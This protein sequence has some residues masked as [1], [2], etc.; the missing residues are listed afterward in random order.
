MSK[1]VNENIRTSSEVDAIIKVLGMAVEVRNS[2]SIKRIMERDYDEISD[3]TSV[4]I[5][6]MMNKTKLIKKNKNGNYYLSPAGRRRLESIAPNIAEHSYVHSNKWKIRAEYE[7]VQNNI[8]EL[9]L[10]CG[11]DINYLTKEKNLLAEMGIGY[12]DDEEINV[13][14]DSPREILS[15]TEYGEKRYITSRIIQKALVSRR[16][17]RSIADESFQASL[18]KGIL[19]SDRNI[20]YVYKEQPN[21][22]WIKT[23]EEKILLKLEREIKEIQSEKVYEQRESRGNLANAIVVVDNPVDAARLYRN[24]KYDNVY[25]EVYILDLSYVSP[26]KIMLILESAKFNNKDIGLW[27]NKNIKQEEGTVCVELITQRIKNVT[28]IKDFINIKR[29]IKINV[30]CLKTQGV[31]I[32]K[33]FTPKEL[34]RINIREL[35]EEEEKEFLLYIA[36]DSDYA[37]SL[38]ERLSSYEDKKKRQQVKGI[39]LYEKRIENETINEEQKHKRMERKVKRRIEKIEKELGIKIKATWEYES[40]ETVVNQDKK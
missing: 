16:S 11:Y 18:L 31:K 22:K 26:E 6:N 23:N 32:K 14:K 13:Y 37:L 8:M 19:F 30:I 38:I 21:K 3:R 4:R 1:N 17:D 33:Y 36:N 39:D 20:Y 2:T 10:M 35:N 28:L 24:H 40:A 27:L 34:D 12:D 29:D 5:K 7:T 25:N 9:M 15:G